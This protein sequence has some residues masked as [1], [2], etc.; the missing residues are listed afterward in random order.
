MAGTPAQ[1]LAVS[2]AER[3]VTRRDGIQVGNVTTK[4]G[5]KQRQR[6]GVGRRRARLAHG[7]RLYGE[8]RGRVGHCGRGHGQRTA[9]DKRD[10]AQVAR[11]A[12]FD[13]DRS[14]VA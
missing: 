13:G 5:L 14:G 7:L 9:V 8:A 2:Q 12:A 10:A 1:R 4:R 3:E 11:Q 6:V